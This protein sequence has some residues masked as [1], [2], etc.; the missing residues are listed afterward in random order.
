MSVRVVDSVVACIETQLLE[1]SCQDP[2]VG[3]DALE[4]QAASRGRDVEVQGAGAVGDPVVHLPRAEI[5][6]I[7]NLA[8]SGLNRF[9][10]GVVP[11]RQLSI[12]EDQQCGGGDVRQAIREAGPFAARATPPA[13]AHQ[14]GG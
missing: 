11:A 3:T 8:S 6:I 5:W 13:A 7:S 4:E 14:A 12:Q 10:E 1:L 9:L 2:E